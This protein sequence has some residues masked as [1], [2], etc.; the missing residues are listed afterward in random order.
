MP[1]LLPDQE[2]GVTNEQKVKGKH[3][4]ITEAKCYFI[5]P[6]LSSGW[7]PYAQ[8]FSLKFSYTYIFLK[9][10]VTAIFIFLKY[11]FDIVIQLLFGSSFPRD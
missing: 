6:L 3:T 8:Y 5:T 9:T 11:N 2:E 7:L 10:P 4:L 1:Q